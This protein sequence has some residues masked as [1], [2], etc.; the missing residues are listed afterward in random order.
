MSESNSSLPRDTTGAVSKFRPCIDLHEGLVKQIVGSTLVDDGHRL[1]E[2][3]VSQHN[4]G[5]FAE[6]YKRDRLSG[7]H[8]IKLGPGNDQAAK[9]ALRSFPG[10]LQIGGGIN[11]ENATQ[12]LDE[13]AAKVIVTS[14]LFDESGRMSDRRLEQL[15]S[16]IGSDKLV[17]DLSCRRVGEHWFV[18]INRWQ[19][20]TDLQL[21]HSNL[22]W[23]AAY[24]SE[25]LIHAADVEGLCQ[26]F[27]SKLVELLSA[28]GKRPITYAGGIAKM[29]DVHRIN[30]L[31]R[32]KI[33]FT[34]GSA[35][36]LFGG[37]G[38]RY[39]DLI[40]WNRQH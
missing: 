12:W 1:I 28:W 2:N 30:Q 11:L 3:H 24:A 19:T 25:F 15:V 34:V 32:G 21:S 16:A 33:D 7:G 37:K 9:L 5:Q 36:D 27:D 10:G 6:R 23:L 4:A 29:Q 22:D 14:W 20:V 31:S 26:G 13:G 18:A 35:L 17:I 40:R 39:D 8:V 38:I